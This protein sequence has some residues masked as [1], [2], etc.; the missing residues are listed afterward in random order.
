MKVARVLAQNKIEIMNIG[1]PSIGP[2][3]V[4]CKVKYVGV[5][6][7]DL[8]IYNGSSFLVK[9]AYVKYPII[10]GHEW[11]GYV[12]KIGN[13]VKNFKPGDRVVGDTCVSCD[14]C[15]DC[16]SGKYNICKNTYGIGTVGN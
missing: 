6:H 12:E 14:K 11:S 8:T 9:D 5:C 7:T 1:A 15:T 10:I 13:E 3:D 4:L 2:G 16:M